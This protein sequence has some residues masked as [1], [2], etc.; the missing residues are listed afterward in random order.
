MRLHR[1]KGKNMNFKRSLVCISLAALMCTSFVSCSS[2][3][4][5]VIKEPSDSSGVSADGR[6]AAQSGEAYISIIDADSYIQ[7]LGKN[8]DPVHNMLSYG[9]V[10]APITGNGDYKVSLTTN[11][12]GFRLET[13]GDENDDSVVP[14]GLSFMSLMIKD[15]ETKFPDAVITVKSIKVNGAEISLAAKAYTSSDDGKDT[16]ANLYNEWTGGMI[17]K[18][19][20]CIQGK[21]HDASGSLESF[22]P[23]Y[24]SIVVNKDDFSSWTDVEVNFSVSG[25]K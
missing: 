18:N 23:E 12:N 15:G 1:R 14:S 3:E 13:A 19:A 7:Y 4:S 10:V 20:R 17:P 5:K 11:T 21:L 6:I 24:S 25:I 16:R 8:D 9:A 2:K 22:A